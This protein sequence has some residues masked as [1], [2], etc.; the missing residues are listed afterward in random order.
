MAQL[1]I[2]LTVKEFAERTLTFEPGIM[3]ANENPNYGDRHS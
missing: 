2:H 3:Q 1:R